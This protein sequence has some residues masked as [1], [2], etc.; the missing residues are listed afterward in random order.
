MKRR[1]A[2]LMKEKSEKENAHYEKLK[3]VRGNDLQKIARKYYSN[4]I[5]L[6]YSPSLSDVNNFQ[7]TRLTRGAATLISVRFLLDCPSSNQQ[8]VS[9]E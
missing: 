5:K 2:R 6:Q 9:T 1:E 7:V 8:G 4:S 3:R